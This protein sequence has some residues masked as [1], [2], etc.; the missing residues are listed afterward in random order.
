M[1]IESPASVAWASRINT[2]M[3]TCFFAIS[4][5]LPRN[6]AIAAI[7]TGVEKSYGRRGRRIIELNFRAIDASLNGLHAVPLGEVRTASPS[8]EQAGDDF[9]ARVTR[10][11]MNGEG[12]LIPVQ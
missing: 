2:I 8:V 4:G 5:V 3:Q 10:R 6:E 11:I 7:K 12:D 9:V 1:P